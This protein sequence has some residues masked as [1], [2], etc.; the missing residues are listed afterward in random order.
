MSVTHY[1]PA[2]NID[3]SKKKS[4]D[5]SSIEGLYNTV[6]INE[7]IPENTVLGDNCFFIHCFLENNV[8][9]S[10]R[11][12]FS[13]NTVIK[14]NFRAG[15]HCKIGDSSKISEG[16]KIGR[17]A[18]IGDYAFIGKNSIIGAASSFGYNVKIMKGS[19][20]GSYSEFNPSPHFESGA[21]FNKGCVVKK[22]TE[23]GEEKIPL[24]EYL[25]S[26]GDDLD[27]YVF[28]D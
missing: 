7:L 24:K 11:T 20:I 16:A 1:L 18:V 9:V 12:V 8:D 26:R 3:W 17:E 5:K 2:T 25:K 28:K 19:E 23:K 6:F 22:I 13:D 21:T 15:D 10:V 27:M 4:A 14:D